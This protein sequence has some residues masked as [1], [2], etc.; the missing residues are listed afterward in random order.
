M[1]LAISNAVAAGC[2]PQEI[3][4]AICEGL[5]EEYRRARFPA[6]TSV[7]DRLARAWALQAERLFEEFKA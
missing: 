6:I 5:S 7:P 2:T 4:E 3:E 1:S